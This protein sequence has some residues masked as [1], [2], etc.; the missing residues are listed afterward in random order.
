M[1]G[2]GDGTRDRDLRL[3]IPERGVPDELERLRALVAH[4]ERMLLTLPVIEQAKGVLVA[5][6]GY[7]PEEAF[8]VLARASQ[9]LNVPLR[10][11]ARRLVDSCQKQARDEATLPHPTRRAV[12]DVDRMVNEPA[13]DEAPP[14]F[15]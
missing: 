13:E 11:V 12:D 10:D 14:P 9:R 4:V 6:Q 5:T 7:H 15:E 3:N 2:A 8:D 1:V